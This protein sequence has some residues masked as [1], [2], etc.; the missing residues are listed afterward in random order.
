MYLSGCLHPDLPGNVGVM[1]TP[2]MG[3]AVPDDRVWAADTGCFNA[4]HLHDDDRYL[5][6]LRSNLT[7][8]AVCLFATAPDVVGD[9]EAT[10]T[11]SKPMFD[12]IRDVGYPAALVAQDGLEELPIPWDSFDALFV[13]GRNDWKFSDRAFGLMAEARLRGKWVHAGRVNSYTR[14]V[15][16]RQVGANSADGTFVKFAPDTNVERLRGWL[17]KLEVQPD[18]LLER[19]VA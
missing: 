5:K 2:M 12:R 14:L 11:R 6:W 13:G 15:R 3:N 7:N 4:P 17:R 8:A 10:L 1:M 18:L 9:A 16:M 19:R